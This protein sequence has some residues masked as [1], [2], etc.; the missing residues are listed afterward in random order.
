MEKDRGVQQL[1]VI[2]EKQFLKDIIHLEDQDMALDCELQQI[3]TRQKRITA[4]NDGELEKDNKDAVACIEERHTLRVEQNKEVF[5]FFKMRDKSINEMFY[6]SFKRG[7]F[8]K[9]YGIPT[10]V[11]DLLFTIFGTI[12]KDLQLFIKYF[13]DVI[14]LYVFQIKSMEKL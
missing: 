3:I 12:Q 14:N 13:T 5:Q 7:E 9:K 8:S 2:Q 4:M 10:L 11:E 6:G 1:N